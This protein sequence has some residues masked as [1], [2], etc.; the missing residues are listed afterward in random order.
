[1]VLMCGQGS[2]AMTSLNRHGDGAITEAL[3]EGTTM[4]QTRE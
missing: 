1:M 4:N 3:E 2:S